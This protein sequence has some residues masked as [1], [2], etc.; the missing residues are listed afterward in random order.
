MATIQELQK[1]LDEKN[2]DPST[3]NKEQRAAVDLAFESGQLKGYAN[4]SEVEKE[5]N[6]GAKIVASEKAKR[7]RPFTEAT[8]GIFPFTGEGVE[9]SDLELLG[10]VTGA[11]LVYLKDAPKIV[12]AFAKNPTAGYGIDK[13]KA[14]ATDFDKFEKAAQ[15]LPFVRQAKILSKSARA[16]GKF[17]DGFRLLGRAPTQLLATEAKA[18]AASAV[19]AGAGSVLYDMAN[20]A[21]DFNVAVNDDLA[22]VSNND[23]K[24]LPYAQQVLVHSAEAMRN[25]LFFNAI[26]SSL[27]PILGTTLKGM[28]GVLGLGGKEAK[29]MTEAAAK[30]GIQLSMS[31]VADAGTLGGRLVAGF[32]KVFGVF[33]LAN[34]FAKKQR[35]RVEKQTFEAFLDEVVTKAP[36]EHVG[37]LNYQ[38]LPTMKKNFE[39]FMNIIQDNYS[40]VD[41]IAESMGNPKFIPTKSIKEV[42]Q[43]F[44]KRMEASLPEPMLGKQTDIPYGQRVPMYDAAKMRE[45]GF[46]DPFMD[47]I[48]KVRG[49]DDAITPTEYQGMMRQIVQSMA[50]TTKDDPRRVFYSLMAAGK[51]DFNK[52][53]D[54]N[55]IEGY[56]TSSNFK[57]EYDSILNSSGKE[58]ADE[59]A[60]G[61]QTKMFDFGKQLQISNGIFSTVVSAFN[62]PTAKAIRNSSANVFATK[63]L[64][65]VMPE[66]R[67]APDQMWDK[68]ISTIFKQ[69]DPGGMREL[70]FLLGVDNPRNPLGKQIFNRARSRYL[71]D[72]FLKS[73]EKQ[74][75]IPQK[76]LG[77]RMDDARR[78]GVIQYKDLE[79]IFDIAGTKGLEEVKRFDPVLSQRYGIGN[80]NAIDVKAVAGE[81]G[82]FNIKKFREAIGYT[83]EA[84]KKA[85]MAKWAEMYGGGQKGAEAANSLKQLVDILDK[86]YGKYISDS[87]QYIMRRIMLTGGAGLAGG[88]IAGGGAAGGIAA[89]LPFALMLAGGGF[90][91]S[92]PKSLKYLLDVYTDLERLDKLGKRADITNM[93]KSMFRLLNWASEEDKDFPNVDPKKINFEEVTD[94]LIKKNILIPELGFSPQAVDPKLR[95]RFYPELNVVDKSPE[96]EVA[97]G[98][99]FLQGSA[100][101]TQKADAVVN[102]QPQSQ[103]QVYNL[104]RPAYEGLVSPQYIPQQPAQPTVT[105]QNYNMLFPNDPLG[106]AIAER[107]QQQ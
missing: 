20:V 91:L 13:L 89:A 50:R 96:G 16:L 1:R 85:A 61:I 23:I 38:F 60:R 56:L 15:R 80:V 2:F 68:T 62:S 78:L 65:G 17:V 73:F 19:G 99:N 63:G 6:I 57:S 47:V 36:L 101:G 24:K 51:G 29:E 79:E 34:T 33:P 12:S 87:N 40:V 88:F 64:L 43:N 21:T 67:I 55:N 103:P 14:A 66:G 54:P 9:R 97:G 107:G 49:M 70:K 92:N 48:N 39:Q 45:S 3:L 100:K 5:R 32:E 76:T 82:Q 102:F 30:R 46:D 72:A 105:P 83:D 106:Q 22:Q 28:K 4:V 26:G 52:I 10:D 42:A 27:A 69:T 44:M 86:E 37:I 41:T 93:P 25:A 71:W 8:K 77:D 53:A 74:P 75:N 90:V 58:A 35:A 31:T 95:S 98:L 18:Q 104:T 7:D 84:S 94:Y 81:A 11:G 59:Y